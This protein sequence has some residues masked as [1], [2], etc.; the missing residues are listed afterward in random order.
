MHDVRVRRSWPPRHE[1]GLKYNIRLQR[2]N[3]R[4]KGNN[5][6]GLRK[7]EG[8]GKSKGSA[9]GGIYQS[10]RTRSVVSGKGE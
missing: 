8:K 3:E 10:G 4:A 9:V 6:A 1:P 2:E 5:A 7:E